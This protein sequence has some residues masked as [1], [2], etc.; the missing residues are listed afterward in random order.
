[1]TLEVQF[2]HVAKVRYDTPHN[3]TQHNNSQYN[4]SQYNNS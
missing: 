4:N 2:V 1:M 3:N